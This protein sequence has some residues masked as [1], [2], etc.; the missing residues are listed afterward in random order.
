MVPI[1]RW[2]RTTPSDKV[3]F[4]TAKRTHTHTHPGPGAQN[5]GNCTLFRYHSHLAM[6]AACPEGSCPLP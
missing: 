5:V 6:W 2:L 1:G 3:N 4:K